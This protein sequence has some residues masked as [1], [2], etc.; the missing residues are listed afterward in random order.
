M[1][2]PPESDRGGMFPSC[3]K[4]DIRIAF[5]EPTLYSA[6]KQSS[7]P[8]AHSRPHGVLESA[9]GN[10]ASNIGE[11]FQ[12]WRMN[13]DWARIGFLIWSLRFSR[14]FRAILSFVRVRCWFRAFCVGFG[15]SDWRRCRV[16][17]VGSRSV[18]VLDVP[19]G[20][21]L[22]A[23]MLACVW[24][25]VKQKR[26]F[27][28]PPQP[29]RRNFSIGKTRLGGGFLKKTTF[30]GPNCAHNAHTRF[31][32]LNTA[33]AGRSTIASVSNSTLTN[34]QVAF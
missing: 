7:Y 23:I 16:N 20:G 12:K 29:L 11:Y 15:R 6:W 27:L 13:S 21:C 10:H 25:G 17:N 4:M 34:R 5:L 33:W 32:L 8:T 18:S 2:N 9:C 1:H 14:W 3:A 24:Y 22:V 19:I 26:R 28:K 31:T 30:G